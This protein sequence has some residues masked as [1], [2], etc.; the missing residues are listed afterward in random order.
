MTG[1]ELIDLMGQA[2]RRV[3]II[4]S[5]ENGIIT[6][7]D[8]EGR[9]FAVLNGRVLN[10]VVPSA[11]LN[12]SNKTAFLNPGGDALWPAP[13]GSFYGYEYGTGNWRV[14]PAIT[15]A[16]WN[17]VEQSGNRAVIRAEIDLVNNRQLGIPREFE[18]HIKISYNIITEY[19]MNTNAAL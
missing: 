13:E 18:R 4:G 15:G 5:P 16:V 8:L 9:L 14:P 19:S 11:I 10:R 12:R 6:A 2:K 1:Q 17:V 7:L 3:H